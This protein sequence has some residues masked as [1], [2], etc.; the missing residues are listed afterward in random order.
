MR[1]RAFIVN[2]GGFAIFVC[3][4]EKP[5]TRGCVIGL[6]LVIDRKFPSR[7]FIFERHMVRS[8]RL[9]CILAIIGNCALDI[10]RNAPEILRC[11]AAEDSPYSGTFTRLPAM[12]L[13]YTAIAVIF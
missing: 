12:L 4:A 7:Q 8:F 3:T 5:L 1:T 6:S 10:P 13:Y 2:R 9:Y 11:T